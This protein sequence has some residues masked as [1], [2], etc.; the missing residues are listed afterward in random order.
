MLRLLCPAQA[1]DPV[2]ICRG[3]LQ[4]KNMR[5]RV[6]DT[7]ENASSRIAVIGGGASGCMAAIA[8]AQA[9]C[10]VTIFEKNE[11]IGKKIYATGNGRCNLTNLFLDSSCYHTQEKQSSGGETGRKNTANTDDISRVLS[12]I[13]RFSREDLIRFFREAGVPVHDRDGYVYPRTDQA[14]TVVEAL[15]KCMRQLGIQICTDCTVL[16]I[17]KTEQKSGRDSFCIHYSISAH[18]KAVSINSGRG[19]EK[20]KG[21]GTAGTISVKA[22]PKPASRTAESA[23]VEKQE[24]LCCDAVI[25]CTGGMAGPAFGCSGDGYRFAESLDHSV[26]RPLPA[27]TRLESGDPALRR[28]AGVRCHAS[29]ML[30]KV[31]GGEYS[32]FGFE[33]GELQITDK[34]I[35]GI[36]VFQISGQA[37]RLLSQGHKVCVRID[38]LPEFSQEEFKVEMDNR[39]RQDRGQML[40]DFL[41]GLAHRKVIDLVLAREG[42]QAEMKARRFS[43]RDLRAIMQKL[44]VF[45]LDVTGTGGFDH[46]QVTS[47]GVPLSEVDDSLQSQMCRGLFLAGE[48]LDVDGRCGGYNLQWAMTSGTLAGRSAARLIHNR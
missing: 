23:A 24:S 15:K 3:S 10:R 46:A 1:A 9:G 26:V 33:D 28:A 34:S 14:E 38:F 40:G 43:D 18:E 41:L 4:E 48:L 37:A 21:K 45:D 16:G 29:V 7:M 39:L 17:E 8:A 20:K 32:V 35:S 19:K 30:M 22:G 11:K 42:L 27:L 36:P 13:G 5:L 2:R 47:G 12:L 31:C 44:R 25:L 6:A